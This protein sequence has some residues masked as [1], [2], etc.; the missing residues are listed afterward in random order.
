MPMVGILV[1]Q[2]G[3]FFF[4]E[5]AFNVSEG[6]SRNGVSNAVLRVTRESDI[7][8]GII[9]LV[10]G[11]HEFFALVELDAGR[12]LAAPFAALS[13][14]QPGTSWFGES[15]GF[16]RKASLVFD[17][18]D[19]C[20]ELLGAEGIAA[21][22]IFLG[23][24]ERNDYSSIGEKVHDLYFSRSWTPRRDALFE[25]L[26]RRCPTLKIRSVRKDGSFALPAE[27]VDSRSEN[28]IQHPRSGI[29]TARSKICLNVHLTDYPYF[30][31]HRILMGFV[32]SRAFVI[33]EECDPYPLV[34][35]EHLVTAK[36]DD[37]PS[38]V[39]EWSRRPDRAKI[40]ERAHEF[41]RREFPVKATCAE[42][43][44]AVVSLPPLN[45]AR[46]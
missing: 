39:E 43:A 27:E 19:R 14:E 30:S 18:N 45:G 9:P 22:R 26:A 29:E 41:Y 40:A 12:V 36:Y 23:Y 34:A 6:L 44:R 17:L 25:R 33:T 37:I 11:P 21:R 28:S 3:N 42:L 15:I 35:G 13:T 10:I 32:S 24:S 4:D 7:P 2:A 8:A 16:L 1:A 5:I 20:V 31:Q 38:V 46:D